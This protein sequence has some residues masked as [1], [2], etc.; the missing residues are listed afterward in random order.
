MRPLLHPARS[1]L[2]VVGLA[3][4]LAGCATG[5]DPDA[6]VPP[7]VGFDAG[8]P[9][10]GAIA[11]ASVEGGSQTDPMWMSRVGDPEI[12]VALQTALRNEGL[13][14]ND[15]AT[16]PYRLF[17]TLVEI[18]KPWIGFDFDVGSTVRYVLT[19]PQGAPAL[20]DETVATKG[21]A[22]MGDSLIANE[23][24][25]MANESAIRANIA[26]FVARLKAHPPGRAG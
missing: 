26:E 2:A 6:M 17:M 13:L 16:A 14:A 12:E 19:P 18:D 4:L 11:V 9:L 1:K 10:R 3:A 5:A 8:S 20:F 24:L 25:R 15:P 22:S 7:P 21:A 23:R